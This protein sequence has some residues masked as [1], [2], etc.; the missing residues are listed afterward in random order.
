MSEKQREI[1][2]ENELLKSKYSI[3]QHEWQ[4]QQHLIGQ[5]I[6][7]TEEIRSQIQRQA[8]FC[9]LIGSTIGDFLWKATH[10]PDVIQMI[11]EQDKCARMSQMIE[12]VLRS[13]YETY[14][15]IPTADTDEVRFVL[16]VIGLVANLSTTDAG[17]KMFSNSENG[18]KVVK[19]IVCILCR[20][21]SPS[22]NRLKKVS[23]AA[24]YNISI[25]PT[26]SSLMEN[27]N[28][29]RTLNEEI[30]ITADK[31][32]VPDLRLF[33]LKLLSSLTHNVCT[34]SMYNLLEKNITESDILCLTAAVD[35]ETEKTA[36]QLLENLR[37]V[38]AQ[39]EKK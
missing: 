17:R 21:K 9:T 3:M 36:R 2:T 33:A 39:Y 8:E 1:E 32:D 24:L 18:N 5:L 38:K 11:L 29:I 34:R 22:G 10:K 16:S 28:L 27:I 35:S 19:L 20:L 7:Q 13:F 31:E 26:A 37:K 6:A 4:C 14:R 30:K 12:H 15:V 23:Y 25:H